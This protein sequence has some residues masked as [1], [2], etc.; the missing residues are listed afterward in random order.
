MNKRQ[1]NIRHV[2]WLLA[3]D[4]PSNIAK[5]ERLFKLLSARDQIAAQK[6]A[7]ECRAAYS[8]ARS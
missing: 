4:A 8:Q 1:Y 5:G 7:A 2:G 3:A 6:Y